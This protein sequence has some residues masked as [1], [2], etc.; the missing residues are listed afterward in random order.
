M[1]ATAEKT[2]AGTD[3]LVLALMDGPVPIRLLLEKVSEAT[4]LAA[5]S[6]GDV[7][8]GTTKYVITGNPNMPIATHNGVVQALPAVVIEGG[9]EWSGPRQRWHGRLADFR[10]ERLP[11][12]PRYQKYQLEVCVNKEKDVWEWLEAGAEPNGRDTRQAR[13]EINR[14]DAESLFDHYVQLTD[15]G[16]A[17]LQA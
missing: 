14:Q 16:L 15:K 12:A 11:S 7:E 10:T 5:W 17:A 2:K 3:D 1:A 13:R 4:V 9:I 6:R 8:L